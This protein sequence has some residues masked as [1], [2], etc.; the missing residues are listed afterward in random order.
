MQHV[1]E[2]DLLREKV[3]VSLLPRFVLPKR[4]GALSFFIE[5]FDLWKVCK[6]C[7]MRR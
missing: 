3:L 1:K 6:M 7:L 5:I 2:V 4:V